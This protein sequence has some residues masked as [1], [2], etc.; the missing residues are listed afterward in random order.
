MAVKYYHYFCA[1]IESYQGALKTLPLMVE[2]LVIGDYIHNISNE[3]EFM[4]I[5]Q[6]KNPTTLGSIS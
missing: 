4:I 6:C 3:F 5:N 1:S 2:D